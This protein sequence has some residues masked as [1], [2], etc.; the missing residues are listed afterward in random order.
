VPSASFGV[1]DSVLHAGKTMTQPNMI[2]GARL[3]CK[4]R[5]AKGSGCL[6]PGWMGEM[7]DSPPFRRVVVLPMRKLPTS[8]S[9][10]RKACRAQ[11]RRTTTNE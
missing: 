4:S 2:S 9:V 3:A 5:G 11:S 6:A 10:I 1:V 7:P 8:W